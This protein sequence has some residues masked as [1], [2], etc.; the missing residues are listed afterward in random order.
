M[1]RK[2]RKQSQTKKNEKAKRKKVAN[3]KHANNS[4]N[5]SSSS[6]DSDSSNDSDS[7]ESSDSDGNRK[8]KEKRQKKGK[9]KAS[10]KDSSPDEDESS[11]VTINS[12]ETSSSDEADDQSKSKKKKKKAAK[13]KK[14]RIEAKLATMDDMWAKELR[15]PQLQDREYLAG[16]SLNNFMKVQERFEIAQEKRNLGE[17]ASSKDAT[18]K[19]TRY[20]AASDDGKKKLHLARW[21]RLPLVPP[22]KYFSQVPK[23]HDQIIR[24]FPMEHLGIVGQIPDATIGH[25][26]NRAVKVTFD[27]FCKATF[28]PAKGGEK[29]GKYA[30]LFQ[31]LE[32]TINYSLALQALW[33]MDHTG[34]VFMKVL[35]EARWGETAGLA[36]RYG[37]QVL[38]YFIGY[39]KKVL[40]YFI[41]FFFFH[42]ATEIP[43]T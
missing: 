23:K 34:L 13:R 8:K 7:S 29:S 32:A 43:D 9:K 36:G 28:K 35:T 16:M 33:P 5:S 31:L 37:K 10:K 41:R 3:K 21:N 24:H 18:A 11:A 40:F 30:D 17:E 4:D 12:T 38:F 19:K 25:M 14:Q 2:K 20:K 22:E 6:S 39:G 42:T 26:H 27:A 1:C 15:P